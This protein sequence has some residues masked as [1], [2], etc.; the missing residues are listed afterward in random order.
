M[1]C[2]FLYRIHSVR[3]STLLRTV[4]LKLNT[5][6]FNVRKNIK[7][8]YERPLFFIHFYERNFGRMEKS[9]KERNMKKWMQE[10]LDTYG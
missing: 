1:V 3:K 2:S 4:K 5:A 8:F 9:S 6:H 10:N 7:I